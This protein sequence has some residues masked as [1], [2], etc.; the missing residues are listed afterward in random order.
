MGKISTNQFWLLATICFTYKLNVL[1]GLIYSDCNSATALVFGLYLAGEALLTFFVFR[2]A[3]QD[4]F[5]SLSTPK[6]YILTLFLHIFLLIKGFVYFCEQANFAQSFLVRDM[7]I[8]LVYFVLLVTAYVFSKF[9]INSLA[10]TNEIVI[11]LVIGMIFFNIMFLNADIDLGYNSPIILGQDRIKLRYFA[12]FGD[13]LPLLACSVKDNEN[14]KNKRQILGKFV[15]LLG[16]VFSISL[17]VVGIGIYGEAFGEVNNLLV[18]IGVFNDYNLQLGR[19]DW[20]GI[21]CWLVASFEVMS[22]FT[23]MLNATS[24][25][26]KKH[27]IDFG[28]LALIGLYFVLI[29][30]SKDYEKVKILSTEVLGYI[31]LATMIIILILSVIFKIWGQNDKK[32]VEK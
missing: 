1:A 9:G 8:W 14:N 10:R 24:T 13:S 25:I 27:K 16:F 30:L 18:K 2:L 17:V 4:F 28:L 22:L 20:I 29:F 3:K 19:L 15:Y 7:P 23:I 6:R 12:W 11:F 21:I 32:I 31:C 5:N 26:A